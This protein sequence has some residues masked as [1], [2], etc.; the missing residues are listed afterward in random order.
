MVSNAVNQK[1][2]K[3]I[4]IH[5]QNSSQMYKLKGELQNI[6]VFTDSHT[7]KTLVFQSQLDVR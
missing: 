1:N 5:I 4:Y 3:N 2:I 6:A 7:I